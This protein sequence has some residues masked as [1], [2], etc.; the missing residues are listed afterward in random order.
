MRIVIILLFLLSFTSI[1]S[2]VN[3]ILLDENF[4]DWNTIAPLY[5]DLT[6]D[7]VTGKIDFG[8]VWASND[9]K[10][11]F[12]R[13]ETGGEINL[14]NN[15][16]ITI[17]I[18]A[19]NN[20]TTGL[21]VDGI[22]AEIEYF[23]GDKSG[24]IRFSGNTKSIGQYE[25]GLVSAPTVTSTQFEF[26]IRLN[27]EVNSEPLF[28][29]DNIKFLFKDIGDG[30]D[31]IP[32]EDGGIGY[33]F[34]E[35]SES[36]LPYYSI[37]K[38]NDEFLR[39]LSYN[40]LYD[41]LFEPSLRENYSR[42]LKAV[43]PEIIAFQEIYDHTSQETADIV[44]SML[45]SG[46][47]Q[48]WYHSKVEDLVPTNQYSTDL[49]VLSRFPIKQSFH[50][51][52]YDINGDSGDRANFAV[53][54]DLR[55]K[56]ETDLLLLNAHP[57]CCS[58]D[59]ERQEEVDKMMLFVREAKSGMTDLNLEKN[60]PI[61]IMGDMNFVGFARQRETFL[62]GD[63]FDNAKFGDDFIPDWDSTYFTDLKPFTTNIP[64][65][66]TWYDED[67]SFSPG[68]LDY[69]IYS[70]SV[71]QHENSYVL[72]TP[73]IDADSLSKYNLEKRDVVL[74]SDHL[75]VVADFS[76][77]KLTDVNG[78][79]KVETPT[80]LELL[81]NYPNPFNPTTIIQYSVPSSSVKL[82]LPSRQAGTGKNPQNFSTQSSLVNGTPQ[83]RLTEV[84]N[85]NAHVE[86]T[87]YD[88][89]GR[90]V[91]TL[92]NQSQN[93]GK[94]SVQFNA[95]NLS[96]GIYY[97]QLTTCASTLQQAQY[98]TGSVTGFVETKK[99]ILLR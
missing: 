46:I 40:V 2:Q 55:P 14:Q 8:H 27:I 73:A 9:D 7:Q 34:S 94:Y 49:I 76:I 43:D 87:V 70:S 68:R 67:N 41:N 17:Y 98:S 52:G 19:D 1:N 63:I 82:T 21:L 62:A 26:G 95:E 48:S 61:I 88:I 81:Q 45:P 44:E 35:F 77:K 30:K 12:F 36:T 96:S 59:D 60:T 29:N 5:S 53:L 83:T 28:S 66:F 20:S 71:L 92:V 56:Y 24:T 18:D 64:M 4:S 93:P 3:R 79:K 32:N 78:K 23:F 90:K 10:Y 42:I 57:P 58:N 39:F 99:M 69:M 85:D 15:N 31:R 47:N 33:T 37:K 89:L 22:G 50:I 13:L 54:I 80:K 65:S 75:P 6:N 91:K 74:A 11:L 72:F 86:L 25:I 84:R 38:E 97:Y 16:S 51:E